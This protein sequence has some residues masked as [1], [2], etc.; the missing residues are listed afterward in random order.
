[1]QQYKITTPEPT[2]SLI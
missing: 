1:M 2:V